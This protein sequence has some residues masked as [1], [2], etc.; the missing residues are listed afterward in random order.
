MANFPWDKLKAETLRSICSDLGY[1]RLFYT[2]EVMLS[3]LKVVQES[4]L[5]KSFAYEQ[6]VYE[7][8][9]E[10]KKKFAQPRPET[11]SSVKRTRGALVVSDY[12]TRHKRKRITDPGP[13]LSRRKSARVLTA[14][15][16]EPQLKRHARP[17]KRKAKAAFKTKVAAPPSST[18]REVFDG[19]LLSA[20]RPTSYRGKEN[21]EEHD[22][23]G[24]DEDAEG[25]VDM[26]H[27]DNS[28]IPDTQ[29][30]S[31]LASSNKENEFITDESSHTEPSE[32]QQVPDEPV[33]DD[34]RPSV[35]G[36]MMQQQTEAH[37][38]ATMLPVGEEV[39][40][41]WPAVASGMGPP[42][43]AEQGISAVEI[44]QVYP[45]GQLTAE[46]ESNVEEVLRAVAA[47]GL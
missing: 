5:E 47:N 45:P 41:G 23:E 13:R 10:K 2:K 30:E 26:E 11:P 42:G 44:H 24:G 17:S 1:S 29:V 33:S 25:D 19:I 39:T 46:D 35:L 31:S 32:D 34:C 3:L 38:E 4:G 7:V 12:D 9:K 37:P 27:E 36:N 40:E 28:L 21:A 14:T 22:E 16:D 6:E 20:P 18:R 43:P 8:K 15:S